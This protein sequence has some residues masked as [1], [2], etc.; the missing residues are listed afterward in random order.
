MQ[1]SSPASTNGAGVLA[2]EPPAARAHPDPQ[3]PISESTVR[4]VGVAALSGIALIHILDSVATYHS[5]RYI[6]WLY[7]ALIAGAI[8]VAGLLLHWSSPLAWW[9]TAALAAG[10]LAGYLWSRSVGLPG[11]APDIGNWLCTL[12]M[13][14]LFVESALVA[15]CLTRLARLRAPRP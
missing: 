1:S 12:G 4:L 2:L 5:T 10:P 15:L 7:I 6:F 14:A 3:A 11:D 8:P 13:A 9:P